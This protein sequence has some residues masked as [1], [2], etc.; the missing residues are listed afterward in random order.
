MV[1][2]ETGGGSLGRAQQKRNIIKEL[3]IHFGN[4]FLFELG[5]GW[6]PRRLTDNYDVKEAI[7][8]SIPKKIKLVKLSKAKTSPKKRRFF[9][10]II[11]KLLLH[12]VTIPN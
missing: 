3:S 8:E 11:V 4:S 6:F 7:H 10:Q 2:K 12:P 5:F 1:I 9:I